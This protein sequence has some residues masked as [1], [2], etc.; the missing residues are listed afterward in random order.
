MH[1]TRHLLPI[2][3]PLHRLLYRATRGWVGDRFFGMRCFL[4]EHRGRKSGVIRETPLLYVEHEGRYLVVGSN[5][6]Q[7]H[8]PAWSLNLAAEPRA[9]VRLGAQRRP[10]IARR[11]SD[12]EARQLWPLLD[13]AFSGFARYRA[14]TRRQID[15][16]ILEPRAHE[17]AERL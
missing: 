4:L 17:S 10:V 6:G 1:V 9:H 5:A 11:A 3:T 7:D 13:S 8:P 15:I 12:A 16:V 2:V 14:G